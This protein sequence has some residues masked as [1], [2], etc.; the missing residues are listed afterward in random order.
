MK[1]LA[2]ALPGAR[3]SSFEAHGLPSDA[4]EAVTFAVLARR[5][6]LGLANNIPAA[7]GARYAVVMGKILPGRR[8]IP[9]A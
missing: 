1:G 3:V 6:V 5:A 4:V 2:D 7:T 9:G 8:G